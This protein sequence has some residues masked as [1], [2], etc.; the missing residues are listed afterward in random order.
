MPKKVF[1]N[2]IQNVLEDVFEVYDHVKL[3]YIR[4]RPARSQKIT[5]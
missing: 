5:V 3:F 1:D 4:E 2:I